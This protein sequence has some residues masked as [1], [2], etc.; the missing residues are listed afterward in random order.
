MARQVKKDFNYK[1]TKQGRLTEYGANKLPIKDVDWD[2]EG[3]EVRSDPLIDDG[4]GK[5]VVIRRFDFGLPPLTQVPTKDQLLQAHKGKI[6]AFLWKDEL[7]L[8]R[9]L[10][11]E[12]SKDNLK[13]R[14]FATCQAKKGSRIL[15]N[16]QLLQN[17]MSPQ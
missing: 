16:P 1:K 8:I 12:M 3:G 6:I 2:V 15:E 5:A 7:E 17:I 14:I 4:S 13:F 11:I 10:K 9:D